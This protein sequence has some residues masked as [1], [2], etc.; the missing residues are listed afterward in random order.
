MLLLC[1]VGWSEE[2]LQVAASPPWG[3]QA[4]TVGLSVPT[5]LMWVAEL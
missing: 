3:A 4:G 5:V 1:S 2:V